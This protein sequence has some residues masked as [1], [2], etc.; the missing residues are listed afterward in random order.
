MGQAVALPF[1]IASTGTTTGVIAVIEKC[2]KKDEEII[3]HCRELIANYK[4]PKSV[5]F[6]SEPFPLSG[7][8]KLLKREVRKVYWEGKERSIN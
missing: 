1:S 4:C 8:G 2:E 5:K 7:A 6:R 3:E